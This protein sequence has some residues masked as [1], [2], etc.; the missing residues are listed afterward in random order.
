MKLTK[1]YNSSECIERDNLTADVFIAGSDQLWNSDFPCGNDSVYYLEF[2]QSGKKIS[3][4]TSVG[5]SEIGEKN[6]EILKRYL[7]SFSMISTREKSTA[8]FLSV[9]LNRKVEWVCD[10]VFLLPKKEYMKFIDKKTVSTQKY[11]MVYLSP[12]CKQLDEIVAYYKKLG[13]TIIL[14]GGMTKRCQCD[15]HIKDAGPKEF[16]SYIYYA[17]V[18]ISTSFHATAFSH[19]FH[20]PFVTLL[21]KT[22]GERIMNLLNLTGLQNRAVSDQVNMKSIDTA[23][24]WEQVDKKLSNHIESSKNYLDRALI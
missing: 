4:S 24:D 13:Y 18:V 19:I 21:P 2:V 20:I 9:V 22:N 10:P 6:L 3:Y 15:Q 23:I 7:P 14:L 8:D 16:L 17:D 12:K 11:A 1:L 5:K